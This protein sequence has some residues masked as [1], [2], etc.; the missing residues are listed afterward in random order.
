MSRFA[1][2]AVKYDGMTSTFVLP[3]YIVTD[4]TAALVCCGAKNTKPPIIKKT[5]QTISSTDVVFAH[6]MGNPFCYIIKALSSII[7]IF[8]IVI[9]AINIHILENIFGIHSLDGGCAVFVL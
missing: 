8:F 9:I 4:V 1:G 3:L 7:D 2:I 6:P 5:K